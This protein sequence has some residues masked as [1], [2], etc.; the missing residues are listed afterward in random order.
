MCQSYFCKYEKHCPT[1]FYLL[2]GFIYVFPCDSFSSYSFPCRTLKTWHMESL[3]HNLLTGMYFV[4][5][6]RTL[7]ALFNI[8]KPKSAN[9]DC[10]KRPCCA[11]CPVST[12]DPLHL[13][14]VHTC[15]GLTTHQVWE[16]VRWGGGGFI[17]KKGEQPL[18]TITTTRPLCI[19]R[20]YNKTKKDSPSNFITSQLRGLFMFSFV[21]V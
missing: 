6:F 8:L 12:W 11:M 10:F 14:T 7:R 1:S 9:R 5:K 4:A 16:K 20:Y 3:W 21:C 15:C 18:I 13:N 17:P 2:C 19:F